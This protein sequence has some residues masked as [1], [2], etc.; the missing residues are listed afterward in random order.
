MGGGSSD[1]GS[2]G[3]IDVETVGLW[4]EAE[5]I[6]TAELPESDESAGEGAGCLG[7]VRAFL[8]GR[9]ETWG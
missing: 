5:D 2:V 7:L 1:E 6:S 3:G 4:T 8:R 9:F